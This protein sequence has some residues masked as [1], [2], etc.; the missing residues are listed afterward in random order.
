MQHPAALEG[1]GEDAK[2]A[3]AGLIFAIVGGALMPPWQGSI[4]DAGTVA[5][6]EG[7]RVSFFLPFLCFLILA[8]YGTIANKIQPRHRITV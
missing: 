8:L 3:S 6:L 2:L 4:I 5:G 1:L 7:V